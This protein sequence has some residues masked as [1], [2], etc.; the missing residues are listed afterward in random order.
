MTR[1]RDPAPGSG[2]A[3]DD[4]RAADLLASYRRRERLVDGYDQAR[5]SL[6]SANKEL[7]RTASQLAKAQGTLG[8][9]AERAARRRVRALLNWARVRPERGDRPG[10]AP[11][12]Q[13]QPS[14]DPASD[15]RTNAAA[16]P[17]PATSFRTEMVDRLSGTS[18]DGGRP[19]EVAIAGAS[20]ADGEER[21]T[22]GRAAQVNACLESVGFAARIV[23]PDA[24][25]P[26]DRVDVVLLLEPDA[27]L[28]RWPR[29]IIRVAWLAD[30]DSRWLGQ[31]QLNDVDV[32]LVADEATRARVEATSAKAATVAD[33]PGSE[34]GALAFKA[35][36][37]GWL[38]SPRV[39]I[40]I[41][42]LTWEAAASWGD[43][44]F[45]YDVQRAFERR[46]WAASVHVFAERDSAPAVRADLALHIMGV[47]APAVRPWQTTVL[48][49]ISHPD[50][51][52]LE[53]CAPY[54]VVGVGSDLFLRYL[55]DW[56][57]TAAP[58]LIPLHQATD[59]ARF[60][61]EPGGPAH[62]VLFVGSSRNMRRPSVDA[63]TG[64]AHDLAVYG[65]NWTPD[66]LDPR[67]LQGEWVPNDELHRLYASAAIVLSDS[68]ADMREEG[69]IMNRVYDA[70]ASGAFVISEEVPGIDT[71][72]D[73]AVV[74]Y[75]DGRELLDRVEYYLA[76]PDE[77]KGLAEKGRRAVLAR[78][79]F[80]AR[81][82]AIL[83]AVAPRLAARGLGPPPSSDPAP[84][85]DAPVTT[86][87]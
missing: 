62:E 28:D 72:F 35:A 46:G 82:D 75:R 69:F 8:Y 20:V 9:R 2:D 52:R 12:G 57:S 21:P 67:F 53:M 6:W 68:Y 33:D 19:L 51:V 61:P 39:A 41:G 30:P 29:R 5:K 70:L 54:D 59:P 45:G 63:L 26:L 56:P 31:A 22:D 3:H 60:F 32:V 27:E 43:T 78:H 44:P 13:A 42:P 64:T 55:R 38:T 73:G 34:A 11:V 65:R 14:A 25:E 10:Q 16:G 74:T 83:R 66:L 80:A 40:H 7:G 23:A 15:Q 24:I 36:L 77:R 1:P 85:S 50:L 71:E 18:A 76:H 87:Q 4:E 81:V 37:L 79:T 58:P 86:A 47:R 49:I 84:A 17:D 48:W